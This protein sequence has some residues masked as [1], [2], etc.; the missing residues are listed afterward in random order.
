MSEML[1]NPYDLIIIQQNVIPHDHIEEI[2]MLTNNTKD[3]SHATIIN[4]KKE[5]GHETNLETRNTLWYNITDEMAKKLEQAVSHCF[6]NYVI[7]KYNCEFKSYEP[8]QFLGYPPGGHYKGHNDGESF[9]IET[10]QWERCMP[11]DV[12]FL[13]YLN[14]QYGGGELE[15]YD[16]G[17][18]IKPKKGMMIAFPSYKEFPHMVHPVTWGHRYTLVSWVGTQKNLYDTIP[19]AGIPES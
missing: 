11:R 7:P 13:F 18:T 9:N 10:R 14:D 6:R 1:Y 12:S 3:I 4:D 15:F 16:L 2:M 8:V 19:R 17:L 5:E